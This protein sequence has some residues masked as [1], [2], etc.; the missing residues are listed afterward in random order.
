M[1][2]LRK[3]CLM[4]TLLCV[5]STAL[6]CYASR[7][8]PVTATPRTSY[9]ELNDEQ[10]QECGQAYYAAAYVPSIRPYVVVG[11]L[12]VAAVLVVCFANRQ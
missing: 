9:P 5:V 4:L 8:R 6:P 7:A 2:A 1:N 10:C 11:F 3:V 12:V